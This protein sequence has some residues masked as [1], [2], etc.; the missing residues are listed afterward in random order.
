[1]T[2]LLYL[3]NHLTMSSLSLSNHLITWLSHLESSSSLESF[4]YHHWLSLLA[5]SLSLIYLAKHFHCAHTTLLISIISKI[6]N[7]LIFLD[8]SLW[9]WPVSHSF[10][11]LIIITYCII[12]FLNPLIIITYFCITLF[13]YAQK[14][15][16]LNRPIFVTQVCYWVELSCVATTVECWPH[17]WLHTHTHTLFN[18]KQW[19]W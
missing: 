11:H 1:M 17:I 9:S 8:L 3:I 5:L 7:S 6:P 13:S 19:W 4:A 12:L 14:H 18:G 16:Q 15:R 2:L 10:I